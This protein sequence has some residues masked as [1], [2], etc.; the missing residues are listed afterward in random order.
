MDNQT[1]TVHQHSSDM[2]ISSDGDGFEQQKEGNIRL[3]KDGE[4]HAEALLQDPELGMAFDTEDDVREYYKKYAKA[5]GFGVT[6]RSSHTDDDGQLKYFTLSCSRYGKTQSNS[7]KLL[8]PNPSARLECKAKINITRH[9]S[10]KFHLSK[11]ILGHNHTLSPL[12]SRLFRCNKKIDFHVKRRLLLNDR[13]GIRVNKNFNSFVVAADGHDN[14][15]FG[16][17]DCRNFLEKER[18]LKLGRGDAEA[19]HDYFVKMQSKNPNFFSVMDVDDESRLRNVFW[20]DARSRALYDTFNDVIT[21][22]TTYLMNKYDMPFAL[23]V[24]VDHHGQSVLLGCALLSN[25]DTPTFVWLFKAWLTYMSNRQL[26][27]IVTDQAKAIQNV[28]GMVFTNSRYRWCLWHIMK[29][30]PE[31]LGGYEEYDFIKVALGNTVY[32]SLT[33]TEFEAAWMRMVERYNLGDN[34]WL[35]GLYDHRHRWVPAFVKDA[36]WADM[37]TTQ[38]SESMNA[39]FDGYVNAK[40][41]LKHFVSQ[42]E[43]ALRDKVEKE[44]LADF[45]SFNSTI[46]CVTSF[47]IEKQFQSAY[48]NAKFK[49]FQEQLTNKMYCDRNFIKKEGAIEI[50]EISE[51]VLIDPETGWRK[52]I[53]YNVYFNLEEFEVKC[54]CR[55]FEFRGI[56]CS[57]VLSVL[58]HKKIK[59]VPSQYILDRWT[60]NV[61]RKHNFIRCKYGGMEDT[62]KAKR[63]DLL[64]NF[65]YP[66]AEESA[67]CNEKAK[68]KII[69]SPIA[70]RCAGRPPSQRKE[71]KV[72]K[73]IREAKE[74]KKKKAEQRE[75]KK[76]EQ[77]EKKK[78]FQKVRFKTPREKGSS[79]KR[80]TPEDDSPQQNNIHHVFNLDSQTFSS[81]LQDPFDFGIPSGNINPMIT[82]P[83]PFRMFI[84]DGYATNSRNIHK[85][86][87]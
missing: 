80:K 76:A 39:F 62:P 33:I 24:G 5:K 8:K 75:K 32:D 10:G 12:K 21:F 77:E 56:L 66:V 1:S 53:V 44:N 11:V 67:L 74:K 47:E 87:V 79:T 57:H 37:S 82:T 4:D 19:V 65:F 83:V 42:Y 81:T 45:N 51:D 36:F 31:K 22:D 78:A 61:K 27:A 7:K 26:T 71:S 72:D 6:R 2:S 50:Y 69:L 23:F 60:K 41:T 64:C 38:R 16:E 73:L 17:K 20:A 43:N 14:L 40:T 54:S 13:A 25:E 48:T 18:R 58:T 63:F 3:E 29:K 15:T 46:P 28:V 55:R 68:S 9:P 86:D 34:D 84:D 30:I 70:V 85:L 59:E 35:K 52:D 49:E